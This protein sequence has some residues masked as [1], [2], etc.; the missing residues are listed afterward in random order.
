MLYQLFHYDGQVSHHQ[1]GK[2]DRLC[3]LQYNYSKVVDKEIT[4][5]QVRELVEGGPTD[6][7]KEL[8]LGKECVR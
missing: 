8:Y 2:E 5:D 7:I 4:D 1:R 6:H 3:Q